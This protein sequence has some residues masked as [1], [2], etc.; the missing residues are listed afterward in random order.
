MELCGL[1][2][3]GISVVYHSSEPEEKK[4]A[5]TILFSLIPV[6]NKQTE[7]H[8]VEPL[9]VW[10]L[11][12]QRSRQWGSPDSSI[13]L[14]TVIKDIVQSERLPYLTVMEWIKGPLCLYPRYCNLR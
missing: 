7:S 12:V 9:P 10:I 1:M 2:S 13:T 4:E 6:T 5:K 11:S 14:M 3:M 8:R